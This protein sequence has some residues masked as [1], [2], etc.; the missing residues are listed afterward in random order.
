MERK[1]TKQNKT[2]LNPLQTGG[3]FIT[4]SMTGFLTCEKPYAEW[5]LLVFAKDMFVT[6]SIILTQYNSLLKKCFI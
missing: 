5:F 2:M 6:F 1:Q 4:L 3:N